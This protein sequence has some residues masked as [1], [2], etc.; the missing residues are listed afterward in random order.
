MRKTVA[1]GLGGL[2]ILAAGSGL[3]SGARAQETLGYPVTGLY[4][5]AAGGINLKGNESIKNQ[6]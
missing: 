2:A 5:S 3:D 6:R 4:I 1:A